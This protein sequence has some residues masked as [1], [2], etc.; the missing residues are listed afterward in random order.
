MGETDKPPFATK[1]IAKVISG[2]PIPKALTDLAVWL[3]GYYPAALGTIGQL[4]LPRTLLA[5]SRDRQKTDKI[6]GTATAYD[7]PP[8][9]KSQAAILKRIPSQPA[10]VLLHGET[11]TGKTRVYIELAK[12]QLKRGKS[13]LVLVPEISLTPQVAAEFQKS[14]PGAVIILHSN[15]TDAQRRN[16]WFEIVNAQRPL[17]LVGPRSALFAP[18]ANIGLII[19]DECH[20]TAYKQEQAPYYH[21]VRVAAK[22]AS[23]HGATY[24]MGSATPPVA[25]YY[26]ADAKRAPI[27]RM[28]ELA[29]KNPVSASAVIVDLRDKSNFS[30]QAHLSNQL[31]DAVSHAL[32]SNQ[33]ALVFLNRRGTARLILCENCG[34]QAL[35]PR[36][37]L[38]LTYHGDKHAM[39]CHTCGFSAEAVSACPECRSAEIV[40]KSIGTKSIVSELEK[41]FPKARIM[42]FDTDNKKAERLEAHY[43]A[44]H[45]GKVDI[46]VGTQMLTKGLDLPKLSVV[47][48]VMADT[49][50]YFP[51]YTASERTYQLLRQVLGRIG[52]GHL[53]GTAI[54]QTY[55]PDSVVIQAAVNKDWDS[56]YR[57][58]IAERRQFRFPPFCHLL[59]LTCS[60]ASPKSAQ[61]AGNKL[62]GLLRN[63]GINAEIIGPLPSFHEKVQGK[64]Q[65]QIVLKSKGRHELVKAI[66]LLPA[67]WSYD[68]DPT[69]L[70]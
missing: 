41:A 44:V 43:E 52:R 5:V 56:F 29:T 9:T 32:S 66:R 62:V 45:S 27:L 23:V 18:L 63:S 59:K 38:P 70:L 30:R 7:L 19:A 6:K 15:L 2:K 65:W 26:V 1:A 53:A 47:G 50:L 55:D 20:D 58:E 57:S 54:I 28:T 24:V 46:L 39:R 12:R 31:L 10:T 13:V 35:C 16:I 48:V 22:L 67:G 14:F 51:D 8:L 68:I 17:V 25:D 49:S 11:G 36:C 34:W 21:A 3:Q 40:F 64:Y 33:Q 69:H 61:S 60:R 42:R 37:D 4:L